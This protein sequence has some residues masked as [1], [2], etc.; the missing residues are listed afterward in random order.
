MKEST[1]FQDLL[2]FSSTAGKIYIV[3]RLKIFDKISDFTRT[4]LTSL[5]DNLFACTCVIYLRDINIDLKTKTFGLQHK[6]LFCI[7]LQ[8]DM[9][10]RLLTDVNL[11]SKW[12]KSLCLQIEQGLRFNETKFFNIFIHNVQGSK[13]MF[14]VQ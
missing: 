11:F 14:K 3:N 8:L 12:Y 5:S 7:H 4:Q 1:L 13:F 2:R 6:I 10:L 9:H